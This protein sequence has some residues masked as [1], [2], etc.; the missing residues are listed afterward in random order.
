M[1]A[2]QVGSGLV[3]AMS[4]VASEEYAFPALDIQLWT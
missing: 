3:I 2:M 4:Y 1:Y